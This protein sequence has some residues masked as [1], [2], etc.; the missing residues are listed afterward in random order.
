MRRFRKTI[1]TLIFMAALALV[2]AM[3]T[4]ALNFNGSSSAAAT[5]AVPQIQRA[6]MLYRICLPTTATAPWV[7]DLR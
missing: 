5:A 7:T 2:C 6:V 4:F 3:P 1:I